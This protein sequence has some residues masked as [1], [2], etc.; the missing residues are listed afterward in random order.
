MNMVKIEGIR[1]GSSDGGEAETSDRSRFKPYALTGSR[2]S[3]INRRASWYTSRSFLFLCSFSS[4]S[5][6]SPPDPAF[7]LDEEAER[8]VSTSLPSNASSLIF[9]EGELVRGSRWEDITVKRG[10][11]V[12]VIFALAS[13]GWG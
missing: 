11:V 6:F 7:P 4:Y 8:A 2:G 13:L 5:F 3:C 12:G 10:V 1:A 9:C